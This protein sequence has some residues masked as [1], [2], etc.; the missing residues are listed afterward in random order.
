VSSRIALLTLKV[1]GFEG[2]RVSTIAG[3]EYRMAQLIFRQHSE[4]Q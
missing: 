4:I 3:A 1:D 2:D